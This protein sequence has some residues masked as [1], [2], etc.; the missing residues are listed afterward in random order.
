M[1]PF[2]GRNISHINPLLCSLVKWGGGPT[3]YLCATEQVGLSLH[4]CSKNNRIK[5]GL[6]NFRT[7]NSAPPSPPP[8]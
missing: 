8:A 7:L 5:Q 1:L 3:S 4:C 2:V 6:I